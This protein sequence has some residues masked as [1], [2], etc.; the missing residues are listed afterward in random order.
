MYS[1]A[2][3]CKSLLSTKERAIARR[4]YQAVADVC[5]YVGR[6]CHPPPGSL[7]MTVL[8]AY[9]RVSLSTESA[10]A[11]APALQLHAGLTTRGAKR[12]GRNPLQC[13]T[14]NNFSRLIRLSYYEI[15]RFAQDDT[16][17]TS[18]VIL[19]RA[20]NLPR[21]SAAPGSAALRRPRSSDSQTGEYSLQVAEM[22]LC[23]ET[24]G[25]FLLG[26]TGADFRVFFHQGAEIGGFLPSAH[27]V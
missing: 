23:I 22:V 20:K 5:A 9:S 19:S 25:K 6:G 17:R 7:S 12:Q 21:R 24:G 27:G 1:C 16:W 14:P 13:I 10:G 2:V 26:Q 11:G 3:E 18:F 15:L 4:L 8:F